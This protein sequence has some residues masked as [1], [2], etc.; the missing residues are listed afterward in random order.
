MGDLYYRGFKRLAAKQVLQKVAENLY[1][2]CLQYFE[3]DDITILEK[4]HLQRLLPELKD[5]LGSWKIPVPTVSKEQ[6]CSF[7]SATVNKNPLILEQLMHNLD[8]IKMH[9]AVGENR[10]CNS[11]GKKNKTLICSLCK[12]VYYCDQNCQKQDWPSHKGKNCKLMNERRM[13]SLMASRRMRKKTQE[14]IRK[15]KKED[16]LK[17][18]KILAKLKLDH[19]SFKFEKLEI[20]LEYIKKNNEKKMGWKEMSDSVGLKPG[21]AAKLRRYLN[22]IEEREPSKHFLS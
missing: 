18:Q 19:Y 13:K 1:D 7:L 9:A 10:K 14:K 21:H 22:E 12:S 8:C 3:G 4:R 6:F 16:V 5:Q 20:V 15:E 11:C 2:Y 17:L